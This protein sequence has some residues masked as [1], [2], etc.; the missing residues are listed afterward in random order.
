[1]I[2]LVEELPVNKFDECVKSKTDDI[3][4]SQVIEVNTKFIVD[5]NTVLT[6]YMISDTLNGGE[7]CAHCKPKG[8]IYFDNRF[9]KAVYYVSAYNVFISDHYATVLEKDMK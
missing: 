6:V 7:M 5:D 9:P 1:M 3:I 4:K 8:K 2:I